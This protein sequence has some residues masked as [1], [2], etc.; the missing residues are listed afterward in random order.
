MNVLKNKNKTLQTLFCILFYTLFLPPQDVN[1]QICDLGNIVNTSSSDGSCMGSFYDDIETI[2]KIDEGISTGVTRNIYLKVAG[3]TC[4]G[5]IL[6]NPKDGDGCHETF[7][8]GP[9]CVANSGSCTSQCDNTVVEVGEWSNCSSSNLNSCSI[10]GIASSVTVNDHSIV[11]QGWEVINGYSYWY[12]SITSGA[13]PS[14]SH[15]TF[16]LFDCGTCCQLEC[17]AK[18][19][20]DVCSGEDAIIKLNVTGNIGMIALSNIELKDVNDDLVSFTLNTDGDIEFTPDASGTYT[21]MVTEGTC[22]TSCTVNV[23]V[24][25]PPEDIDD[26]VTVCS[27]DLYTWAVDGMTYIAADSPVE[28]DLIDA[29]DC[30]YKATLI[31]NEYPKTEDINDEVTVCPGD[32][33]IWAVDGMTY[34]AADSPVELDLT[35]IND[36]PYKANL[37]IDEFIPPVCWIELKDNDCSGPTV[38]LVASA[39]GGLAPYSFDWSHIP[40]SGV[41]E[42]AEVMVGAG[43]YSVIVTD[44]NGCSS[45]PCSYTVAEE[46]GTAWAFNE[47]ISYCF[48]DAPDLSTSNPNDEYC[49][50]NNLPW[51]FTTLITP[52]DIAYEFDLL[53]GAPGRCGNG[54]QGDLVGHVTVE[55][56]GTGNRDHE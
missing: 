52:S 12:Y 46:C 17:T 21:V 54:S 28:L 3:S 8:A 47:D 7:I 13:M 23:T 29:N 15:V 42:G 39:T 22:E 16:G 9:K 44:A 10:P 34:T 27:G 31:I 56:D 26:M 48:E 1:A 43:T 25:T 37:I 19:D 53:E 4:C 5:E 36:C 11:F 38:T 20:D 30:P 24:N 14:I 51:G 33:Y 18:V 32:S 2:I 50:N 35:D 55:Y 6:V 41:D 45:D 40:G 49:D